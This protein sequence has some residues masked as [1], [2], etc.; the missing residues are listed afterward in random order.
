MY[1]D[2]WI[3]DCKI[4]LVVEIWRIFEGSINRIKKLSG[5][6]IMVLKGIFLSVNWS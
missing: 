2:N 3:I 5:Q 4:L 1:K 6:R